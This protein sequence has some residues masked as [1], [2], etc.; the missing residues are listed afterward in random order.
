MAVDL[1]TREAR[2]ARLNDIL[3]LREKTEALAAEADHHYTNGGNRTASARFKVKLPSPQDR[4]FVASFSSNEL[5]AAIKAVAKANLD[6]SRP[7]RGF[8]SHHTFCY[9]GDIKLPGILQSVWFTLAVTP[10]D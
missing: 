4:A 6:D 3:G 8:M 1:K 9:S 2:L 7:R 5:A 10:G